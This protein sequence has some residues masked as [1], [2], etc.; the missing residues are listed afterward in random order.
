MTSVLTPSSN[1][2]AV[3]QSAEVARARV[4]ILV[5]NS[6][7]DAVV[8]TKFSIETFIDDLLTVLAAAL[9]ADS[10]DFTA[11]Y[12]QWTL[13][14]VGGYP[15]PRTHT[16]ADHEVVDG[17]LLMLCSTESADAFTPVVEDI[18][19]ALTRINEREFAEF[20]SHAAALMGVAALVLGAATVTVLLLWSWTRTSDTGWCALPALALGAGCW[21]ASAMARRRRAAAPI[22]GGTA[23]SAIVLCAA[24]AAMLVP[25]AHGHP[26]VL[27]A[28]NLAAGSVVAAIVA[29]VL[30]RSADTGVPILIALIVWGVLLAIAAVLSAFAELTVR[31]VAGGAVLTGLVLLTVVPRLAVLLARIRP[32]DL[33]DPGR[34]IESSTLTDI[35]DEESARAAAPDTG[36]VAPA[37]SS[38][39]R[40]GAGLAARAWV[41]LTSLRGLMLAIATFLAG[42][43]VLCAAVS[44]GGIREIVLAGAV[45]GLLAMRARWHP[46]RMQALTLLGAATATAT[47]LSVVLVGAY[48]AAPARATVAL[49][50]AVVAAAGC[51]AG[52]RLPSVRLSPVARRV[53]D[54]LEYSLILLVPVIACWITGV[55][56][57]MRAI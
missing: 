40:G 14:R 20:D 43:A 2:G 9:T 51:V 57:A 53:I 11:P 23:L 4:A 37:G 7:V 15:F 16:L 49:G 34:E 33:P 46:D 32:P 36:E 8:P 28:A 17:T 1:P 18:T 38:P 19:D 44:P 21:I 30:L 35:F 39:E 12:G 56:T 6:Q 54:L 13:S 31:Q 5:A 22:A 26:G 3:S 48:T 25:A 41:A 27:T 47:G 42:A 24:G 50:I 29:I 52:V 55:Y 10:V 45:A